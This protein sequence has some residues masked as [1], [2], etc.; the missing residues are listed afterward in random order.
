M[1]LKL[2]KM[3]I[4]TY[5]EAIARAASSKVTF[6]K[7][8]SERISGALSQDMKGWGVKGFHHPGSES[9]KKPFIPLEK[10]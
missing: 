6:K 8:N 1:I 3:I 5:F 9:Y 10:L 4:E 7:W 2:E